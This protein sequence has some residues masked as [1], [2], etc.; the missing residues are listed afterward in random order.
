MNTINN[1]FYDS[2][3]YNK[4]DHNSNG[5]NELNVQFNVNATVNDISDINFNECNNRS[6]SY[7]S[8]VAKDKDEDKDNQTLKLNPN[9]QQI[10]RNCSI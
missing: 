10:T 7:N 5:Q 9:R 4:Y 2:S 6:I 1:N 8:N 3:K